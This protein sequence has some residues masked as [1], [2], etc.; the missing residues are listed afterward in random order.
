MLSSASTAVTLREPGY[1]ALYRCV[2]L[3][4]RAQALEARL[5]WCDLCPRECRVNRLQNELGFCHSSSLPIVP[6]VCAHHGEEPAISGS[7]GSGTVFFGNCNM[8]CVYCQNYQ[9]SQD[10]TKQKSKEMDCH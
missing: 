3:E 8:R 7:K 10:C 6:A 4:R 5:E 2:E 1:L 9:I